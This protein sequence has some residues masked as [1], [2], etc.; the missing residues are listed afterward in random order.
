[1]YY[2]YMAS[3]KLW[4]WSVNSKIG[5][6]IYSMYVYVWYSVGRASISD[7]RDGRSIMSVCSFGRKDTTCVLGGDVFLTLCRSFSRPLSIFSL[8]SCLCAFA[9]DIMCPWKLVAQP[10]TILLSL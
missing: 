5:S 2:I 6:G 7:S 3:G 10:P 1:M 9:N 4:R 8:T